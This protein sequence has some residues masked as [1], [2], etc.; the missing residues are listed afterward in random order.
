MLQL[1]NISSGYGNHIVVRNI[2]QSIDNRQVTAIV[3]PNGHG[4][5]TLM[6]TISG[7]IKT[8]GGRI[9]FD[10]HDI[11][12]SS[13]QERL[14]RGIVHVP[15]GDRLFPDMTVQENLMIGG[16]VLKSTA[17][18]ADAMRRVFEL[19]P[20]V[21]DRKERLA[22]ALSGGERRMVGIARGLMTQCRF[23]ML[24]EPSLG[25]APVVVEGIY[26]IVRQLSQTGYGFLII[27]ENLD[28][29]KDLADKLIFVENGK[30]GWS[31]PGNELRSGSAVIRKLIGSEYVSVH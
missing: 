11:T 25:L 23:V 5:S 27:E 15:Q 7:L 26:A 10:G 14:A 4:K 12:G 9:E 17:R 8:V 13:P 22:S 20:I 16:T 30:I 1:K 3:G 21:A 24:D 6:A 2:S 18:T 29:V 31:G 19:L 28:R